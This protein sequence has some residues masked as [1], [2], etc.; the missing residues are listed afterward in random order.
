MSC[1]ELTFNITKPTK[2]AQRI[3]QYLINCNG[4]YKNYFINTVSMYEINDELWRLTVKYVVKQKINF[5]R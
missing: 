3:F 5:K 4:D 1:V 2:V